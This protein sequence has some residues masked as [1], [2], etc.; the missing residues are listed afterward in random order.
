MHLIACVCPFFLSVFSCLNRLTYDLDNLKVGNRDGIS[1][2]FIADN[3]KPI[4][5]QSRLPTTDMLSVVSFTDTRY[6][7]NY[8]YIGENHKNIT[9]I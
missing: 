2:K 8:R 1:V 5:D 3:R 6:F 9:D 4:F 7:R